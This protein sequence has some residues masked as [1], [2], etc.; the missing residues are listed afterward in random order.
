MNSLR[1]RHIRSSRIATLDTRSMWRLPIATAVVLSV[2][3][4][5]GGMAN[6]QKL[7]WVPQQK[8]AGVGTSNAPALA[9]LEG[10]LYAVWKGAGN[11]EGIYYASFN[12][13][14]WSA[15][16]SVPNVGTSDRPALAIF[17]NR[18]YAVWKG[19]GNDQ[20]IYYSY[21]PLAQ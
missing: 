19:V 8:I 2:S 17:N 7:N 4:C 1:I 12:G 16:N 11:D 5:G 9:V 3:F 14:A 15:Q 18:L 21:A 13:F 6:A 10:A 20:G